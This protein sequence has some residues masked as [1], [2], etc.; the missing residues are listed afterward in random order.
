[1]GRVILEV[2]DVSKS[3]GGLKVLQHASFGMAEGEILGLIGPN[4]AGKSTLFNLITGFYSPDSGDIIFMGETVVGLK[5]HQICRRGVTRTFQLVQVSSQMTA[6]ENVLVGAFYGRKGCKK[7]QA[8]KEALDCIELLGLTKVKDV[9]AS[10]LTY[11]HRRLIEIARAVAA[12]PRIVLLDEPLAGLNP[13]ETEE[14]MRIINL[15]RE[16]SSLSIIWIEHKMDAVFSL[17]KRIVV[18]DYGRKI[19]EGV[20]SE[21]AQNQKVV[22]A[23]L[24]E[25]IT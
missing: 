16:K 14:I 23:Y 24:G 1:M 13:A 11:S 22:E 21:I 10:S 19:A 6:L 15:I 18:L 2:S 17:C 3:F 4:G 5:P 8:M 25:P 9:R 20:P 12:R 7:R